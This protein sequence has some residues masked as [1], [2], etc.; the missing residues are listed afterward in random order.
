M[1]ARQ[2]RG[3]LVHFGVCTV[4]RAARFFLFAMTSMTTPADGGAPEVRVDSAV[5]SVA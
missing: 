4:Q 2:G 5:P 3:V 1:V